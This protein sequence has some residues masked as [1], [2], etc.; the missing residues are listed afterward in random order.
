[1]SGALTLDG[2]TDPRVK[3]ETWGVE[4]VSGETAAAVLD[5]FHEE[6]KRATVAILLDTSESMATRKLNGAVQATNSFLQA[7][8]RD[9]D[10]EIAVYIFN[11]DVTRLQPS[12]RVGE[13]GESLQKTVETIFAEGN[14]ALYDA[15]CQAV[16]DIEAREAEA[17]AAGDPRLYG[18][19]L[20]SDGQDTNSQ[21]SESDMFGCLPSGETAEG[22]KIFTIAY[23]EDADNNLLERI[24]NRTNGKFFESNPDDIQEVLLDI[25]YEQ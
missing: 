14:T 5:V 17:E 2:G 12:G 16:E 6:K 23:G 1:L 15:V 25:L 24:A 3:V 18:I 10:D 22:V 8:A 20:L 7:Y 4:S 21:R 11:D 13:V 9:K 19:V